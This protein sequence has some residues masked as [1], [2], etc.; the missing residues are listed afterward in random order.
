MVY[1]VGRGRESLSRSLS[2]SSMVQ[3]VGMFCL[4]R[5]VGEMGDGGSVLYLVLRIGE[6]DVLGRSWVEVGSGGG[7]RKIR[8]GRSV[9]GVV[10][11][12]RGRWWC[13]A[14]FDTCVNLVWLVVLLFDRISLGFGLGMISFALL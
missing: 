2:V 6:Y 8:R 9:A 1:G 7:G 11:I 3:V 5:R 13:D 10:L 14:R 12:F 4:G